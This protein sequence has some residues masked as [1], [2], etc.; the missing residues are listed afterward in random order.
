[1]S[2]YLINELKE[3]IHILSPLSLLIELKIPRLEDGNNFGVEVQK[4]ILQVIT[5]ASGQMDYIINY[6][7]KYYSLRGVALAHVFIP[8]EV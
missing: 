6:L 5:E 4:D 7:T 8:F 3:S 1:M 2:D